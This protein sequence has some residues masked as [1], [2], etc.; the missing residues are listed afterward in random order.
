MENDVK[1]CAEDIIN[2][3]ESVHYSPEFFDLRIHGGCRGEIEYIIRYIEGK[4]LSGV[5]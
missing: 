3:I 5:D 4:Y 2:V 1:E